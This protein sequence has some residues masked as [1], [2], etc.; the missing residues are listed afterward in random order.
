MKTVN[1]FIKIGFHIKKRILNN[2]CFYETI[3]YCTSLLQQTEKEVEKTRV[4]FKPGIQG[5]FS[6]KDNYKM[7]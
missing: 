1:P 4:F 5:S 3:N 7:K 2:E 6:V